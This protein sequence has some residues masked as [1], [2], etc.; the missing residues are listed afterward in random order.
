MQKERDKFALQEFLA[1]LESKVSIR[2]AFIKPAPLKLVEQTGL[3]TIRE[4]V[5]FLSDSENFVLITPALK[6]GEVE[7]S[8]D[9]LPILDYG[10][11]NLKLQEIFATEATK[12]FKNSGCFTLLAS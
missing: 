8:L 6:Y 11:L 3:N 10:Q 12:K 9:L 4:K 7:I 2:Y 1:P 5:I